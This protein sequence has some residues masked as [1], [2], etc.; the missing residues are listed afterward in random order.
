MAGAALKLTAFFIIIFLPKKLRA[1]YREAADR[2]ESTGWLQEQ[3]TWGLVPRVCVGGHVSRCI[4]RHQQ[5]SPASGKASS[6]TSGGGY[7]LRTAISSNTVLAQ[8]THTILCYGLLQPWNEKNHPNPTIFWRYRIQVSGYNNRRVKP[9]HGRCISP[10][11]GRGCLPLR[12][13]D[14]E[15]WAARRVWAQQEHPSVREEFGR[16]R[17]ISCVCVRREGVGIRA[18]CSSPVGT[19]QHH[20]ATRKSIFSALL[21]VLKL[22][23]IFYYAKYYFNHKSCDL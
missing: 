1:H 4:H 16:Q 11:N 13:K 17:L 22:Y 3:A 14:V 9:G 12:V 21:P 19:C 2:N 6:S 5:C 15:C 10:G 20:D 7:E 23:D 18:A 8:E